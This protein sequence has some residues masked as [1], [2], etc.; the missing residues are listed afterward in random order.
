MNPNLKVLQKNIIVAREKSKD[1]EKVKN[2]DILQ[3]I[4]FKINK[5]E[6]INNN[7]KDNDCQN[8]NIQYKLLIKL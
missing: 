7:N 1:K 5:S 8:K 4:S 2:N 6:N 3:N